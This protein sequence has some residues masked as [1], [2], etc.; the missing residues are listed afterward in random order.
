M[1]EQLVIV[2]HPEAGAEIDENVRRELTL[3][4]SAL[5]NYKRVSG[6]VVWETDF[7][8]TAS[9]KIKR[10]ELA[11]EIGALERDAVVVAI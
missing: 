6:Y 2:L 9:M 3:R 7:P 5:R 11:K 4:N 8:R 10:V 1:G